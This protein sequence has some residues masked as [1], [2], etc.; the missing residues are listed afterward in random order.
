MQNQFT[1]LNIFSPGY[2]CPGNT[3]PPAQA[4]DCCTAASSSCNHCF[5]SCSSFPM[6][7]TLRLCSPVHCSFSSACC[8]PGTSCLRSV[9]TS[10]WCHA[11]SPYCSCS[12]GPKN[13]SCSPVHCRF[14]FRDSCHGTPFPPVPCLRTVGISSWCHARNPCCSCPRSPT[15]STL[16]RQN[17][18]L[19]LQGV[20]QNGSHLVICSFV[21]FY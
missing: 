16:M 11:R 12:K 5:C 21:G 4:W 14:L 1:H 2:R 9:G 6:N 19:Q 15:D 17:N 8:H 18:N 10:S 20:Q 7:P 13:S 3:C